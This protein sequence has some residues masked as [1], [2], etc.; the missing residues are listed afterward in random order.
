MS[1]LCLGQRPTS[2]KM[3]CRHHLTEFDQMKFNKSI[4]NNPGWDHISSLCKSCGRHQC[5][6]KTFH[7]LLMLQCFRNC[8]TDKMKVQL[9]FLLLVLLSAA[10]LSQNDRYRHFINQHIYGQ[11]RVDRCD[12]VIRS[13]GIKEANTNACKETNT[14][15]KAGTNLIK[16]ICGQAGEPY[17]R[18]RD[19]RISLQPFNIIVCTL[20]NQA[21]PPRCEYRGQ[22]R[23]RRIV[24]ACENGLP[25]HFA[26]DVIPAGI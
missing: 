26:E 11:M 23:T 13:R 6:Y 15:I 3:I 22:D 21:R 9:V 5:L 12:D 14:F 18:G 10:V 2:T 17:P 25:V 24:I 19:L 4:L 7:S 16:N 20:R 8:A 1:R